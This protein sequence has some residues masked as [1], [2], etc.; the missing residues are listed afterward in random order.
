MAQGLCYVTC[1][2]TSWHHWFAVSPLLGGMCWNRVPSPVSVHRY[3]LGMMSLFTSDMDTCPCKEINVLVTLAP[4]AGM[5]GS[6]ASENRNGRGV[7][8]GVMCLL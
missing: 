6:H 2:I 8:W 3:V 5:S 7:A 1:R 4:L